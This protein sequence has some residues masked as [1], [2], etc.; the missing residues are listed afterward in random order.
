MIDTEV[1]FRIADAAQDAGDYELAR[2]SFERGVALGDTASLT[3]LA[4]IYDVGVGVP[5]DK[6]LAMGLYQKAWRRGQDV[7]AANNIAILYREIGRRGE[8]FRWFQRAAQTGDG[9]AHLDLAKCY[10]EG[11][12]VRK[13]PQLGL[14]CLA[15]AIG[16]IYI[17]E[18]EREQAL[19]LLTTLKP[20]L[21]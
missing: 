11:L 14:R 19:A 1:L 16:S 17:S 2:K 10:L 12:G 20:E 7:S 4:F 21:V 15:V 6:S 18:D 8:M 13:N 5:V 3:R 9:S